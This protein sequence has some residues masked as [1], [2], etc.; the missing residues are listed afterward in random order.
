MT[1][2]AAS[3]WGLA[4]PGSLSLSAQ[5]SGSIANSRFTFRATCKDLV[6][7]CV[8]GRR[9]RD[10]S[11][12]RF[13]A[14]HRRCPADQRSAL[15]ASLLSPQ[16]GSSSRESIRLFPPRATAKAFL[17]AESGKPPRRTKKF[18]PARSAPINWI[19]LGNSGWSIISTAKSRNGRPS[20]VARS[21]FSPMT[22]DAAIFAAAEWN[23]LPSNR[24]APAAWLVR[25]QPAPRRA[26]SP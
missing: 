2:P 22:Q 10:H 17:A 12:P 18:P 13:R 3:P 4:P 16:I 1:Q 5:D 24:L 14:P 7:S 26:T 15:M 23:A 20:P 25:I 21:G 19:A 9:W 8:R 11:R 6:F